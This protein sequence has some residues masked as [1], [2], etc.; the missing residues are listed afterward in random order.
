MK[1][2]AILP[3]ILI[4]FCLVGKKEINAVHNA[5]LVSVHIDDDYK[6]LEKKAEEQ[7]ENAKEIKNV[8]DWIQKEYPK[9]AEGE[10]VSI[11]IYF[12][13]EGMEEVIG[14][15]SISFKEMQKDFQKIQTLLW[16]GENRNSGWLVSLSGPREGVRDV[17]ED[18]I[19]Q[20]I[21]ERMEKGRDSYQTM[22]KKTGKCRTYIQGQA[23]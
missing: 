16:F 13:E 12:F 11:N 5:G 3:A 9:D 20:L 14:E 22:N 15:N 18:I 7:K 2:S 19:Y 6:I 8:I 17:Y 4:C 1:K 23:M 10:P 21:D